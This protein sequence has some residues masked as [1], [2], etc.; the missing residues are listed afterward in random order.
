MPVFLLDTPWLGWYII[1]LSKNPKSYI[2]KY[3][4]VQFGKS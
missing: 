4:E 2:L 1:P 3:S